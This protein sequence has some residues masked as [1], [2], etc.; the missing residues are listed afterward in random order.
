M[1]PSIDLGCGKGRQGP[2]RDAAVALSSHHFQQPRCE[3]SETLQ[4]SY[5]SFNRED[6]FIPEKQQG[7][8]H[9]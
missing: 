9:F 5:S 3:Y 4:M 2:G 7:V 8:H 6:G 1:Y